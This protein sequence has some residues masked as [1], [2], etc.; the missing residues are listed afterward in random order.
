MIHFLA[1][2]DAYRQGIGIFSFSSSAIALLL[3]SLT[4]LNSYAT[5]S[6]KPE[7]TTPA[8]SDIS[9]QSKPRENIIIEPIYVMG[10]LNSSVD[11]GSTVS[12]TKRY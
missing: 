3:T 8:K 12:D 11:A 5:E 10:E 7:I 9:I 1:K 6:V 4:S 2:N